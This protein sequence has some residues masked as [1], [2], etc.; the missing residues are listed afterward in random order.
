MAIMIISSQVVYTL[1]LPQEGVLVVCYLLQLTHSLFLI[2]LSHSWHNHSKTCAAFGCVTR[3]APSHTPSETL[4]QDLLAAGV[5]LQDLEEGECPPDT[6]RM[7]T[8]E[9]HTDGTICLLI[10][11]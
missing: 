10:C 4:L 6:H 2:A 8:C 1:L 9:L 3:R 11:V 5:L 7:G